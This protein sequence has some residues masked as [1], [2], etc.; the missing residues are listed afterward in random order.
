MSSAEPKSELERALETLVWRDR[1]AAFRRP[2]EWL[3][4]TTVLAFAPLLGSGRWPLAIAL[5][6]LGAIA[7]NALARRRL[8]ARGRDGLLA[9]ALEDSFPKTARRMLRRGELDPAVGPEA[10]AALER[11]ARLANATSRAA[12]EAFTFG[13]PR[14]RPAARKLHRSVETL[15]RAALAPLAHTT[16]LRRP[17]GIP[18]LTLLR[19]TEAALTL[20]RA[21]AERLRD[22]GAKPPTAL[23]E[24]ARAHLAEIRARAEMNRT[25]P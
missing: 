11:C 6:I 17:P 24:S 12:A 1:V 22:E 15:L 4:W 7:Q 21:E 8:G 20:L 19:E 2:E 16:L 14:H 25:E 23:P 3:R 9:R 13:S 10:R 5:F 18:A